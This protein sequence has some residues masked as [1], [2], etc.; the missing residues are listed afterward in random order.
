MNIRK[1]SRSDIPFLVSAREVFS[2]AW[3]ESMIQSAFNAGNFYGFIA[4]EE[5][6][7]IAFLTFS[8]NL[9]TADLQDIF[10]AEN[11]RKKG[12]GNSLVLEFIKYAKAHEIKKLFLEVRCSNTPAIK[13]YEKVGFTQ[14]SIRKKYYS[15]GEDALIFIK[16]L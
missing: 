4:E 8:V 13:L 12:V 9:D 5:N 14:I 6:K 11:S 7:P 3:N 1:L 16:E 2:D 10:V 15:D